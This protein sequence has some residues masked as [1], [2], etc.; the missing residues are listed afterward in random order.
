MQSIFDKCLGHDFRREETSDLFRNN[1]KGI[2]KVDDDLA[3]PP[4]DLLRDILVSRKW[5]SEEDHLRLTSV[6]NGLEKRWDQVLP[7][8]TQAS[9]VLGSSRLRLRYSYVRQFPSRIGQSTDRA[10]PRSRRSMDL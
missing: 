6:L 10:C 8:K 2:R 7:P 1:P 9:Q 3:V 5:D 4:L